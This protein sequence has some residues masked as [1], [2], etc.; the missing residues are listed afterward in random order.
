MVF[1]DCRIGRGLV[2]FKEE[3][4]VGTGGELFSV[5]VIPRKELLQTLCFIGLLCM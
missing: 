3:V 2:V 1:L 5:D 4:A